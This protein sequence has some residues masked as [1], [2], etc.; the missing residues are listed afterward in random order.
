M[1]K[2]KSAR[3]KRRMRRQRTRQLVALGRDAEN[4]LGAMSARVDSSNDAVEQ[5]SSEQGEL[6]Q[7]V[8]RLS[9]DNAQLRKDIERL[10]QERDGLKSDLDSKDTEWRIQASRIESLEENLRN[11]LKS[12]EEDEVNKEHNDKARATLLVRQYQPCFRKR[13]LS[14]NEEIARLKRAFQIANSLR[15][16]RAEASIANAIK[17]RDQIIIGMYSALQWCEGRPEFKEGQPKSDWDAKIG[18]LMAK[19]GKLIKGESGA[20][21]TEQQAG[22]PTAPEQ[23]GDATEASAG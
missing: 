1:A 6:K 18:P 5:L 23:A 7:Q 14:K 19:L 20:H 15:D 16:P 11:L 10:T 12:I 13:M 22:A 8:G 3:L 2:D 17:A 21:Q 4:K 9:S